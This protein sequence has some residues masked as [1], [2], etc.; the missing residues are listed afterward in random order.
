M[1]ERAG[2][3]VTINLFGGLR[4]QTP[5]GRALELSGRKGPALIAYLALCPG[6]TASREKLADLFWGELDAERARNN[7]RQ[8]LAALR[9]ECLAAG[10]SLFQSTNTT[11]TLMAPVWVDVLEFRGACSS[12]SEARRRH[13]ASCYAGPLLDGFFSGASDFDD[14]VANVR[15]ALLDEAI[16]LLESLARDVP[17]AEALGFVRKL[18]DLDPMREASHRLKIELL[19]GKHDYEGALKHDRKCRTTFKQEYGVEPAWDIR[20]LIAVN[21]SNR[22]IVTLQSNHHRRS[23]EGA[24][25]RTITIERLGD[26]LETAG[27][28]IAKN[29]QRYISEAFSKFR[30]FK[31]LD[32]EQTGS[33]G[34]NS[35]FD[36]RLGGDLHPAQGHPEL[37]LI[38]SSSGIDEVVWTGRIKLLDP[39]LLIEGE[40]IAR[41]LTTTMIDAVERF[42]VNAAGKRRLE[43]RD[44]RAQYIMA[45]YHAQ[46]HTLP[47]YELAE[48]L[49][50]SII[51]EAPG[52]AEAHAW[53]AFLD[54]EASYV[55]H[56]RA[57]LP[58][59]MAKATRALELDP[60]NSRCHSAYGFMAAHSGK[61]EEAERHF[62]NAPAMNPADPYAFSNY[63]FFRIA[64]GDYAGGSVL[65]D[66]AFRLAPKAPAHFHRYR[67]MAAFGNG[68]F[69]AAISAFRRD[70]GQADTTTYLAA[71]YAQLGRVREAEAAV[72]DCL[73]HRPQ[74][75]PE[76]SAE[77]EPIACDDLQRA[78]LG[79]IK[80]LF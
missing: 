66:E 61:F 32:N 13:A 21:A 80:K 35:S 12:A 30:T 23:N 42:E 51:K 70:P 73:P 65:L 40:S 10:F 11:V 37:R 71:A 76:R 7:L 14:W 24:I 20:A 50:A 72:M 8:V 79:G 46:K 29:L 63:A 78:L 4:L 36:Y 31:V 45:V 26:D 48:G 67:G 57:R 74:Y 22:S 17:G 47:D 1:R 56:E 33:F 27:G 3:G 15:S 41:R 39:D 43:D 75:I 52:F 28:F 53:A 58:L 68:N 54:F 2:D 9:R 18:I 64:A 69:E 25:P 49:F 16:D 77:Y 59:A 34:G 6:M 55:R 5:D 38:L 44:I 60:E 19:I 62:S